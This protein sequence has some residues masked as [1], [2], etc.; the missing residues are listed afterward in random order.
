MNSENTRKTSWRFIAQQYVA[1]ALLKYLFSTK[2]TTP[3]A[4][5]LK[6]H[7]FLL[8]QLNAENKAKNLLHRVAPPKGP[9][10][11]TA[12]AKIAEAW[13]MQKTQ[14]PEVH[15]SPHPTS[16]SRLAGRIFAT[17]TYD[18]S[19]P[20]STDGLLEVLTPEYCMRPPDLTRIEE[21]IGLLGNA[22]SMTFT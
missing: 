2:V 8:R 17:Q 15:R 21:E 4:A 22:L 12:G 7:V 10:S 19:D 18:V 5:N 20:M 13:R 11:K 6:S 1:C 9:A 16:P 14:N 3:F